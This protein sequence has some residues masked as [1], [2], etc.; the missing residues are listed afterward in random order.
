MRRH[1]LVLTGIVNLVKVIF[2]EKKT[3]PSTNSFVH[4]LLSNLF[5]NLF[6]DHRHIANLYSRCKRRKTFIFIKT[7]PENYT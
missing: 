6:S 2:K 1:L 7:L 4:I 3:P 5:R